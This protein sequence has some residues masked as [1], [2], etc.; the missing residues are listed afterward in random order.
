MRSSQPGKQHEGHATKHVVHAAESNDGHLEH[1][2]RRDLAEQVLDPVQS[3]VTQVAADAH[4]DRPGGR[5]EQRGRRLVGSLELRV[6]ALPHRDE[7]VGERGAGEPGREP[8]HREG[9]ALGHEGGDAGAERVG[10]GLEHVAGERGGGG[11]G[12]GGDAGGGREEVHEDEVEDGSDD[13]GGEDEV[14]L[15]EAEV[16]AG[17]HVAEHAGGDADDLLHEHLERELRVRGDA[18]GPAGQEDAEDAPAAAVAAAGVRGVAR[19]AAAVRARGRGQPASRAGRRRGSEAEE[20]RRGGGRGGKRRE[21]EIRGGAGAVGRDARGGVEVGREEL[22]G[23]EGRGGHGAIWWWW[24][25]GDRARPLPRVRD[26]GGGSGGGS[27]SA[28]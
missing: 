15:V 21:G 3:L 26:G 4:V 27:G 5:V 2:R 17:G 19:S 12:G 25:G 16:G 28:W 7:P 22:G 13:E 10:A 14:E 18:G 9:R 20:R 24:A 23:G 1:W 11:R 6:H 8:D